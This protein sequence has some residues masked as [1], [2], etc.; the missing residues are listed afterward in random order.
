MLTRG[1]HHVAVLTQDTDRFL[2][3]WHGVFDAEVVVDD[4]RQGG[5]VSIVHLGGNVTFTVFE[6]DG[7]DEAQQR[8]PMFQRGRLDHVGVEAVDEAAYREIRHRLVQRGACDDRVT[9]FGAFESITARDPDGLEFEVCWWRPGT[10]LADVR[11][12]DELR[13]RALA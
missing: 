1:L 5:R 6:I 13:D 4:P 11:E 10:T 12:P 9:D 7:N 8:S 3:F 2:E